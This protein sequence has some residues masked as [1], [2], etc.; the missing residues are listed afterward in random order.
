MSALAGICRD[1]ADAVDDGHYGIDLDGSP[2]PSLA[3]AIVDRALV[4]EIKLDAPTWD[5]P[6]GRDPIDLA[7]A[8]V[9]GGVEGIS[10][11]TERDRFGGSPQR[12]AEVA[13][14]GP[15]TLMKD[16]VLDE[17]Q[18][19]CARRCGASAVLLIQAVF[20]ADLARSG[21]DELI[22]AAHDRG[23]EVLLEASTADGFA[24]AK[25]SDADLVAVNARRLDTLEVDLD[26][27]LEVLAAR[28]D[29]PTMLLS[30]LSDRK[31]AERAWAIADGVLVGSALA[32]ADDPEE[33]I[34]AWRG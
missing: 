12:L 15:P 32:R 26:R 18:I 23:L 17:A 2:G 21:R 22:D 4:A 14:M 13:G 1:V 20:E 25:R 27:A 33:V 19:E 30:G 7:R 3:A 6:I 11:L 34:A 5:E 29:R 16:F 31:G 9:R 10:V 24:A 28:D 8:Y